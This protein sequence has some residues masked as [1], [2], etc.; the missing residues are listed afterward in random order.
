MKKFISVLIAAAML[1][2]L[3]SCGQKE[4]VAFVGFYSVDATE[5]DFIVVVQDLGGIY[6]E[7]YDEKGVH[8]KLG[9]N[10]VICDAEG[11]EISQSDLEIGATLRITYDGTL[12]KKNPKTIKAI[13]IEK[14]N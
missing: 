6:D 2:M 14:I 7:L 1:F 5:D 3:C 9:K 12:A 10:T 13:K 8:L 4:T 11:N